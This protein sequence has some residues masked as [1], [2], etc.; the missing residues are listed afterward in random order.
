[1][2]LAAILQILKWGTFDSLGP[3]EEGVIAGE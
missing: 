2:S 1:M 3:G